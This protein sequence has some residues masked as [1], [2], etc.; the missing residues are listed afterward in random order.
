MNMKTYFP[1]N[2]AFKAIINIIIIIALSAVAP[3][4]GFFLLAMLPALLFFYSGTLG[5]FKIGLFFLISFF[6]CW[7]VSSLLNLSF[8]PLSVFLFGL[9]GIAIAEIS[10]RKATINKIVIYPALLILVLVAAYLILPGLQ[11]NENPWQ[12]IKSYAGKQI[13]DTWT[14]LMQ[15]PL[16]KED[17]NFFKQNEIAF[18]SAF[19]K[20]VP[21]LTVC[22]TV[23]MVWLN[24]MLGKFFL[25][26][27]G[28]V[29]PHLSGLSQ[30]R[31]PEKL[32]WLFILSGAASFIPDSD[33][34]FFS[35]NIFLISSFIYVF[36][37]FAII[38]S[39]FQ[40]KNVPG[41]FRY[42]FYIFIA[43]EPFLMI[44]IAI[45]GLFDLWIDFRRFFVK[46]QESS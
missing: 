22:S 18:K 23:F 4:P 12:L 33:I 15:F 32:I 19:L 46:K 11:Q 27:N 40:N 37:G 2:P 44:A 14:V 7:A 26:K 41:F 13:D 8:Q 42:F 10:N 6:L 35:V 1:G 29:L 20:I 38:S 9:M 16:A 39:L 5:K 17:I 36:Q 43:V 34:S 31:A 28:V 3:G 24:V 45:I 21:S 25:H 30:W